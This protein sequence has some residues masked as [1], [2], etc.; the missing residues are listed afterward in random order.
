VVSKKTSTQFNPN[1]SWHHLVW[2][3]CPFPIRVRPIMEYAAVIWDPFHLNSIQHQ[4]VQRRAAN[5]VLNDFS[6]YSSV[7]AMIDH[8]SWPSLEVRQKISRLQTLYNIINE[9]YSLAI[10][11]CFISMGRSTTHHPSHYVLPNAC[12]Y[13]HQQS[14]YPR[15]IKDWNNLPSHLIE[16]S[17]IILTLSFGLHALYIA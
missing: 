5:W 12:T 8:L 17:V 11:L 10:P 14:F 13:S 16:N 1:T 3:S 7:S 15:P 2:C 4:K 9:R 6:R